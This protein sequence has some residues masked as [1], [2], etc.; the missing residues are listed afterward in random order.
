MSERGKNRVFSSAGSIKVKVLKKN[1]KVKKTRK[2]KLKKKTRSVV[3]GKTLKLKLKLNRKTKKL[4]KK[5]MRRK[6]TSKALIKGRATDAAG[7]SS[8]AKRRVKVKSKR[9]G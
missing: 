3:A 6:K 5:A 8:K 9:K 4:V 7:N 1:G 2:L